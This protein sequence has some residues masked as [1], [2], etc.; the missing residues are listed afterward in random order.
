MTLP[1]FF[2]KPFRVSGIL[3]LLL[4]LGFTK[5]ALA[6]HPFGMGDSSQLSTMQ[7]LI[8]GIGHPVFGP[9]HFLFILAIAFVGLRKPKKWVLPLLTVGLSGSA[10]VQLMPLPEALSSWAEAMVSLT[11]AIEG[12]II[13]TPLSTKWLFPMFGLHGYLLGSTILGAE[14]TPLIGYFFGLLLA[15]G[16]LLLLVTATSERIMYWI[17]TNGR[18][19]TAGIWIGI[20]SAFSWVAIID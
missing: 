15:Q 13:L 11:L 17:G 20:G 9:D 14:T 5:Q 2:R 6:H 7:G 8:S 12:F 4:F 16:A 10:L 18:I 19:L 1:I 3:F